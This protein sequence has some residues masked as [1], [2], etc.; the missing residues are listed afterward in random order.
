MT[1]SP[2][3]ILLCKFK[4]NETEPY[5]RTRYEEL[6]T[7]AGAGKW[8]M[9]D[10]FH[11]MSHG[12]LDLSG[13]RVL[14]WYTL[15]LRHEDYLAEARQPGLTE[16][17]RADAVNK[18]RNDLLNWARQAAG[19]ARETLD[20]YKV[21]VCMNVPT[22]LFG[23]GN[24]AV[25]HDD[26][27]PLNGMSGMSPSLLG[28]EMGHVYG[29]E[30]SKE[31]GSDAEYGDQ[32]DVMSTARAFMAPHPVFKDSDA[33][34]R[35]VF[36]LGPGLNAANMWRV[37]WLDEARTW[38][39]TARSL[40]TVVTLR[41]LH[42]PDLPGFLAIRLGDYFVEFRVA[43]RWDA[44]IHEP[45][46]L[47]HRLDGER[48]T[49]MSASDGRQAFGAG[50]SYAESFSLPGVISSSLRIEVAAID[51]EHHW[52]K[53]RLH[54]HRSIVYTVPVDRGPYINPQVAWAL[55]ADGRVQPVA[56]ASPL[57][58]ALT[59]LANYEQGATLASPDLRRAVQLEAL[60]SLAARAQA[61]MRTLLGLRQPAAAQRARHCE[62]GPRN[63]E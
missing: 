11:D 23:G 51:G 58:Q 35:P 4:D 17:Q 1:Q 43:E 6:F 19:A 2:W 33:A 12:K 62:G 29:L 50:S 30:H 40:D 39:S 22:D 7:S 57:R 18:G 41:P 56:P 60:A 44:G 32:W 37:G 38:Q 34:G 8:N 47:L 59:D 15:E 13:S 52:A 26:R 5:T 31:D 10:F 27:D 48:S 3:A 42:R 54:L 9:P 63:T 21:L 16:E 46:V 49:L 24:G 25:C 14:G 28:Q 45:A 55:L 36:L 61:Q 53:I 20:G